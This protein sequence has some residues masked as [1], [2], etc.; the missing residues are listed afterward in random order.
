MAPVGRSGKFQRMASSEVSELLGSRRWL[1]G[2]APAEIRLCQRC[3]ET[4]GRWPTA[5]VTDAKV[6]EGRG[7]D[8]RSS[9]P[10]APTWKT[11]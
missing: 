10:P 1:V 11:A 3:S 8:L 7:D 5:Q 6:A 9:R 2:A 4:S